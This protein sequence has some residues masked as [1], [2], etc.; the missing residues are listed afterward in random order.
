MQNHKFSRTWNQ[1]S[2]PRKQRKYR[3]EAPLHLRQ[4]FLHVHLS[5]ELRVKYGKRNLQVKKADKVK[6]LRGQ[7]KKKEGKVERVNITAEKVFVTGIE[8]I[9]KDGTKTLFPLNPS[10]LMI[11]EL[12]LADKKRKQKLEKNKSITLEKDKTKK[13]RK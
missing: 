7:F 10:N 5:P 12:D 3:Y 2:Q 1:S 11:M 9:K 6:V 8:V 13:P 4:K